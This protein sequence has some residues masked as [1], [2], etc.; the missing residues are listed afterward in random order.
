MLDYLEALGFEFDNVGGGSISLKLHGFFFK[1]E[2]PQSLCA[3]MVH[4]KK[5]FLVKLIGTRHCLRSYE[6]YY[7]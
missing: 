5:N 2:K 3:Y 4:K 1:N 6:Y 7:S